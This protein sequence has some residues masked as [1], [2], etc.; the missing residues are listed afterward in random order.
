MEQVS[1]PA[2]LKQIIDV[3]TKY[4]AC[5]APDEDMSK[6]VKPKVR[7]PNLKY[8]VGMVM[9]YQYHDGSVTSGICVIICDWDPDCLTPDGQP[10]YNVLLPSGLYKEVSE[11][12]F[13]DF[14]TVIIILCKIVLFVL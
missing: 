2:R 14:F 10:L 8:A 4:Q 7:P 13:T 11:G 12:I 5:R 9:N 1:Y 3:L 6:K